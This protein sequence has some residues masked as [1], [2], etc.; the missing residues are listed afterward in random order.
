GGKLFFKK[1]SPANPIQLTLSKFEGQVSWGR[2]FLKRYLPQTPFLKTSPYKEKGFDR[3]MGK[4]FF[5][6]SFP[7]QLSKG[8]HHEQ[9]GKHAA[10]NRNCTGD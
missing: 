9:S 8:D 6:E 3:D 10:G 5:Q 4:Y 1:V 2:Y 7:C